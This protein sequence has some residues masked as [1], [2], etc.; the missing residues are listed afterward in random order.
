MIQNWSK[1]IPQ[2]LLLGFLQT[3]QQNYVL[4]EDENNMLVISQKIPVLGIMGNLVWF[5]AKIAQF[6]MSGS[7]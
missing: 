1:S 4:E 3:L 6:D 2:E 5:W 7:A